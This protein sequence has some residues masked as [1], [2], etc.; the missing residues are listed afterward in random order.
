MW[1]SECREVLARHGMLKGLKSKTRAFLWDALSEKLD[2]DT[3][4]R[5]VRMKLLSRGDMWR[6]SVW[7]SGSRVGTAKADKGRR[8]PAEGTIS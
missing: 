2:G 3:L 4:S 8:A 7:D 5:E 1:A 6:R